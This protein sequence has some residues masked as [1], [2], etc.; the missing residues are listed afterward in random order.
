[1]LAGGRSSRYGSSKAVVP[2]GGIPMLERALGAL[3]GAGLPAVVIAGDPA[4]AGPGVEVRPDVHAGMG[5]LGGLEA[6][7]AWA[8][9]RGLEGVFL[10]GCDMPLVTSAVVSALAAR[11][12]GTRAVAPRGSR[13]DTVE[14]L[15]AAYPVS[16]APQ[17]ALRIA[18]GGGSLTGL[19]RGADALF[20]GPEDLPG[21]GEAGTVFFSVNTPA[22]R[23]RAEAL[24]AGGGA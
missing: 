18:S 5:P 1:M 24:I 4:V 10:L 7:L 6:A 21:A 19:L 3:R 11:F 2:V 22:D 23:D 20:V 14:P 12:D 16:L 13:G 17:V 8:L 15:C 9:E